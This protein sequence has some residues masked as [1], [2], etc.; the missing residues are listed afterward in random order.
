MTRSKNLV[1]ALVMPVF[2]LACSS[3]EKIAAD[4]IG[5]NRVVEKAA[6]SQVLYNILRARDRKPMHFTSLSQLRGSYTVSST[7]ALSLQ[8][9]FGG[10]AI[11][12]FPLTPSLSVQGMELP[13]F[14]RTRWRG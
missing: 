9:P 13:L 14:D 12:N 7:G 5:Y 6:N 11:N 2:L 8:V 3:N 4:A 1:F 10:D